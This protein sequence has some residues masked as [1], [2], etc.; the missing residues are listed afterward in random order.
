[1]S[2]DDVDEDEVARGDDESREL[3]QQI[4]GYLRFGLPV[5]TVV[6][7]T[8]GG[9]LQGAAAVVLVLAAGALVGV[10]AIFWASIRTLVGETALSGADA[11]ALGAPRAEEE[12]KRA[13]LRA[14]KDLEFERSVGKISDEDYQALVAKYRAEGKRLMRMLDHDALPGRQKVEDLVAERLYRE[15]LVEPSKEPYRGAEPQT[16]QIKKKKANGSKAEVA[17]AKPASAAAAAAPPEK[18]SAPEKTDEK[19]ACA[20]CGTR[21]DPDA[22]FCKKCGAKQAA[23]AGGPDEGADDDEKKIASEKGTS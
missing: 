17:A 11:Y 6:C 5:A 10:I 4:A 15:G 12:Q 14:L 3:D 9:V 1:M 21:N 16:K 2:Q 18:V 19:P 22:V 8:V 20:S 23:D 13:V 7:A